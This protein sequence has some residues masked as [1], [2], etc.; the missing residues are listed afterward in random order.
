[1]HGECGCVCEME[2]IGVSNQI[3]QQI[4]HLHYIRQPNSRPSCIRRDSNGLLDTNLAKG[5]RVKS[6]SIILTD[7][8]GRFNLNLQRD[9]ITKFDDRISDALRESIAAD[10]VAQAL[11]YAPEN[12]PFA[13]QSRVKKSLATLSASFSLAPLNYVGYS[14]IDLSSPWCW[15]DNGWKLAAPTLAL[16]KG[17]LIAIFENYD[18]SFLQEDP[19]HLSDTSIIWVKTGASMNNAKDLL[20]TFRFISRNHRFLGRGAR[21]HFRDQ[22]FPVD[23]VIVVS[24]GAFKKLCASNLP[25]YLK[26]IVES[27]RT[28]DG[29]Y[30]CLSN[31]SEEDA[32]SATMKKGLVSQATNSFA[33]TLLGGTNEQKP[34]EHDVF[35]H[36]WLDLIGEDV[37]PMSFDDRQSAFPKA[38]ELLGYRIAFYRRKLK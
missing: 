33:Y 12:S 8:D 2:W 26:T 19:E 14:T 27:A 10:L 16:K 22:S 5:V 38:F 17:R 21:V 24:N 4:N 9:R 13:A 18:M 31:R 15:E 35:A 7:H 34:D 37:I 29:E 25:N 28:L 6:P 11:A 36:L 20:E 23:F 3:L 1:G 30:V 32:L